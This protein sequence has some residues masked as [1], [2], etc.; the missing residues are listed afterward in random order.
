MSF[1]LLVMI[2]LFSV[3]PSI[4]ISRCSVYEI[5]G[6]VLKFTL[7]AVHKIHVGKLQVPYR[8][9]TAGDRYVVI[10]ECLLHDLL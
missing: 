8:P 5:V 7:A 6:E 9:D 1:V 2:L 4:S 10:I 3:L